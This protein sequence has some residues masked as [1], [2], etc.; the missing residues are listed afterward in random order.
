MHWRA[1]E[2]WIQRGSE[3]MMTIYVTAGNRNQRTRYRLDWND[4][5]R[6]E[7]KDSRAETLRQRLAAFSVDAADAGTERVATAESQ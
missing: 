4:G 7:G 1:T 6:S 3:Q 5:S 2:T